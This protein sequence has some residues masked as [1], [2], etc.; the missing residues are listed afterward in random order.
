MTAYSTDVAAE[1]SLRNWRMR[2]MM[3]LT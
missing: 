1:E 3:L 2:S